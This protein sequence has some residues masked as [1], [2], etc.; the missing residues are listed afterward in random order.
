MSRYRALFEKHLEGFEAFGSQTQAQ[1]FCPFHDDVGS[2]KKG[3]NVNLLTGRWYCYSC[4]K[5][6]NVQRFMQLLQIKDFEPEVDYEQLN[7]LEEVLREEIRELRPT[8]LNYPEGFSFL[9]G[10]ENG[11]LGKQAYLYLEKRGL[12][13]SQMMEYRIGYCYKGRYKGRIIIPTLDEEDRVLY[14]VARS[15]LRGANAPYL[16][17]SNEVARGKTEVLFNYANAS[18]RSSIVVCEGVFDAMA[19]GL[20]GVALFG[21][22]VSPQQANLLVAASPDEV[23]VALD[24][25]AHANALEVGRILDSY[26]LL[27]RVAKLPDGEDPGSLDRVDLSRCLLAAEPVNLQSVLR[28]K[29]SSL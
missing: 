21:K 13:L 14:F 8:W 20:N 3:F 24:G 1:A 12:T 11:I 7:T 5:G 29:L 23:V 4:Q 16:N 28:S 18:T 2:G 6:G 15:F 22:T 9:T 19:V 26:G 27:V 17:P 10:K 25:D